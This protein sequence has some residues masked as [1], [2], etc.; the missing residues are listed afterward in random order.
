MLDSCSTLN[1]ISNKS[2]L[3]DLNKV[4]AALNIHSTGGVSVTRK[5]GYL[6]NYPT[7]VWYLACCH[8][9]ILSLQNVTRH[10]E[11]SMYTTVDN[12]LILHR[13][14]GQQHKFT[15]SGKSLYKWEYTM[16]PTKD[17]PCCLFVTTVRGQGGHYTRHAYGRAQASRCLQNITMCPASHHMSDIAISHL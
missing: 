17:N 8:A 2:W 13:N 7:P 15:P 1:L 12:A 16:D 6:G 14:N 5:M 9:N 4:D 11:V 10:Y 3:L